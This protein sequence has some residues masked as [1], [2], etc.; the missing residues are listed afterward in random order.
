MFLH[1]GHR[2]RVQGPD[3]QRPMCWEV[4]APT[5]SSCGRHTLRPLS[6]PPPRSLRPCLHHPQ[7][8][9]ASGSGTG[10]QMGHS[11]C[12]WLPGPGHSPC[13]DFLWETGWLWASA[14]RSFRD[15]CRPWQQMAG[16]ARTATGH[17]ED[18]LLSAW[19]L[20]RPHPEERP[21]WKVPRSQV[22]VGHPGQ[23][24]LPCTLPEGGS[25]APPHPVQ[26]VEVCGGTWGNPGEPR[27]RRCGW[28]PPGARDAEEQL[29]RLQEE[30]TYK[31][32]VDH[33]VGAVLVPCGHLVCADCAP[34]LRLCPL[35]RAPIRS[36]VHAFLP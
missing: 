30:R 31:V 35:C 32:C 15:V 14:R 20:S 28:V 27:L 3:I 17:L 11:A 1:P 23:D 10:H 16:V 21:S 36:C 6:Y 25:P 5:A 12:W 19:V 7:A 18:Q 13:R 24:R 33:S 4:P 34:A 22:R 2:V 8:T 9:L 26:K 29:Q